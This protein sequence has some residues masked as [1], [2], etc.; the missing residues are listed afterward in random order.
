MTD[1]E[2]KCTNDLPEI[3]ISWAQKF[4]ETAET[5][6]KWENPF[7]KNTVGSSST[8][9]YNMW[10]YEYQQAKTQFSRKVN[11]EAVTAHHREYDRENRLIRA[12]RDLKQD[13]SSPDELRNAAKELEALSEKDGYTVIE[14]ALAIL[15]NCQRIR[16]NSV[17]ED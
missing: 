5:G 17:W 15:F 2:P 1:N 8:S 4:E 10:E 7:P 14:I 9:D 11:A 12:V 13:Y 3:E 6:K 16:N